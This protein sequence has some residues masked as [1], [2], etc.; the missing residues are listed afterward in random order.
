MRHQ[1]A[2]LLATGCS[3][4]PGAATT[5]PDAVVDGTTIDGSVPDVPVVPT[6][7]DAWRSGTTPTFGAPQ[8]FADLSTASAESDPWLN[9]DETRIVFARDA[10]GTLDGENFTAT[11]MVRGDAFAG[12]M[13]V[14]SLGGNSDEGKATFTSDLGIVTQA[15]DYPGSTDIYYATPTVAGDIA[16]AWMVDQAK[17]STINSAGDH[18]TDPWI[19]PNGKRLYFTRRTVTRTRIEVASRSSVDEPFGAPTILIDSGF[20]DHDPGLSENEDVMLFGSARPG[21][22]N[23]ASNLWYATRPTA[24][25]ADAAFSM[26]QPLTVLNSDGGDSDPFLSRDGCS[27]Y[28]TSDRT[29]NEDLYVARMM[30]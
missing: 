19:S 11:R 6:C 13:R 8:R 26:A 3:F 5:A 16:S 7:M 29:G 24:E 22:G 10:G 23:L 2:L 17:V 28:F 4:S 21:A 18:E 15:S 27:I 20:S 9:A 30:L 1:L 25:P 14:D 12:V